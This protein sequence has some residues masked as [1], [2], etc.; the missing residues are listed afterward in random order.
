V[1]RE[2]DIF[3]CDV[4]LH[5]CLLANHF[6]GDEID[7]KGRMKQDAKLSTGN[8]AWAVRQDHL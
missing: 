5:A 2:V 3:G 4:E 7:T 8:F 6:R 1:Q